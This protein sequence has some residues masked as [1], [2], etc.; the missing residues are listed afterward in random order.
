M[1]DV[2][3]K[4]HSYVF[5]V[6]SISLISIKPSKNICL[7]K[8]KTTTEELDSTGLASLVIFLFL[9]FLGLFLYLYLIFTTE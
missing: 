3:I 9:L 6:L 8:L 1:G 7:I 4:A 2:S 5:P